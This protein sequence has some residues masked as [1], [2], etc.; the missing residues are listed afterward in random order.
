MQHRRDDS[1][2]DLVL[3]TDAGPAVRMGLAI[4]LVGFGGFM[5][6][7]AT[8]PLDEGAVAPGVVTVGTY[9]K[10]IQHQEGGIIKEI[11]VRDGDLVAAGQALV[12]LDEVQARSQAA[13]LRAQYMSQFAVQV[14]LLAERDHRTDVRWPQPLVEAR[15]DPQIAGVLRV[16]E[17]LFHTRRRAFEGN[18]SI[19]RETA[20]GLEEQ[21]KGLEQLVAGKER[22][23]RLL[24]ED[25]ASNR[26]LYE[27]RFISRTKLY[28]V[29]RLQADVGSSMGEDMSKL[30][31]AKQALAE[32]R[33]KLRQVEQ[34]Y[35]REVSTEL[36][37][38][39]REANRLREQLMGAED[40]VRRVTILA[41]EDG[42]VVALAVHTV[43]G[44]VQA[45]D[46]LMEVVPRHSDLLVDARIP[47]QD[48]D[49]IYPGL[50]AEVRFTAFPLA[51]TPIVLGAV[52]TISADRLTEQRTGEPYYLARVSVPGAELA[53][54]GPHGEKVRPGMSVDVIFKAGERTMLTYLFKPL[55]DRLARAFKE[56]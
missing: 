27:Q 5:S 39:Q 37:D 13:S 42:V 3:Q 48:V 51:S 10:T 24:E 54:L 50:P 15:P 36:T 14:R 34:E 21:V 40:T 47:P 25:V 53:K 12:R 56:E 49:R 23:L 9:R 19:L 45:G 8:A 35:M 52:Q 26:A 2:P 18:L 22:Q 55:A 44:V 20:V 30:A 41:P 4:L 7:A 29:E 38:A 46:T 16:Q 11:L 28:E 6:W 31:S 17:D 33:L 1:A 32:V 43:G